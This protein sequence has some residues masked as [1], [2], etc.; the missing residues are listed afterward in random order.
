MVKR[1]ICKVVVLLVSVPL[2]AGAGGLGGFTIGAGF[3]CI[4]SLNERLKPYTLTLKTLMVIT[5][6]SGYAFGRGVIIGGFGYGGSTSSENTNQ[7]LDLSA[8]GGGFEI[9]RIW[10]T[11]PGVFALM[12]T[13]GGFGY[14]LTI[15]PKLT[16]IEF[17]SLILNPRRI[18]KLS[19]G[20][21]LLGVSG[22]LILP[23]TGIFSLG[24]KAGL[25][26]TPFTKGWKLEDGAAVF[27]SPHINQLTYSLQTMVLL[28]KIIP[29][30]HL[31]PTEN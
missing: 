21:V 7:M 19:S 30:K 5:G 14:K 10:N 6:G 28:G 9:G 15:R 16:D 22:M 23:I 24:L 3:P 29:T 25:Y 26:Y 27:N 13:I 17:D 11:G 2:Y 20:S 18:A 4:Q 1:S 12:A 8:G 31:K